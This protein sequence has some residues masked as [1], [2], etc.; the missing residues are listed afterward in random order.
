MSSKTLVVAAFATLLLAGGLAAHADRSAE[1]ADAGLAFPVS[2]EVYLGTYDVAAGTLTPPASSLQGAEAATIWSTSTPSGFFLPVLSTSNE[3]INIGDLPDGTV[4]GSFTVGFTTDSSDPIGMSIAFYTTNG[5]N[6]QTGLLQKLNGSDAVY[7]FTVGNLTGVPG[8][9]PIGY[10][11]RVELTGGEQLVIAGPDVDLDGATDWGW[12]QTFTDFGN[13]SAACNGA[14]CIG[15]RL[16]GVTDPPGAQGSEDFWDDFDPPAWQ[17][18]TYNGTFGPFPGGF[19]PATFLMS[20]ALA[21]TP[22]PT[23]SEAGLAVLV[24]VL[25]ALAVAML[26][27]RRSLV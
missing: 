24:V 27:R 17:N 23:L 14:P 5:M 18:G 10:T 9:P 8:D 13:A 4:I 25:G 7:N 2:R 11:L 21:P 15:G 1:A 6:T 3:R 22:I 16:A 26:R 19:P 12:G 20:L